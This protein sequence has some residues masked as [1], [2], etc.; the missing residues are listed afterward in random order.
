MF[1]A[2]HLDD[3]PLPVHG[4]TP[5]LPAADGGH[6]LP[7][8]PEQEKIANITVLLTYFRVDRH[9]SASSTYTVITLTATKTITNIRH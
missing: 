8:L 1:A 9:I 6:A 5:D 7:Q 4:G 2:H 3:P